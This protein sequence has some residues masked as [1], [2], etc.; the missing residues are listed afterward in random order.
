MQTTVSSR[1]SLHKL[2]ISLR[3]A[4]CA[5]CSTMLISLPSACAADVQ[6]GLVS[7][8][9]LD[10]FQNGVTPD[11]GFTNTMTVQ[12][13]PGLSPGKFGNAFALGGS[14]YATN[15]HSSES[16]PESGL[17][18][19]RANAFTICMWV[20]GPPQTGKYL[21]A[22]G[23]LASN[24][25]LFILQTGQVAANNAKLDVIIRNDA[26][27]TVM[28][29]LVSTTVV[30]DDAWHHVAWVDDNGNARLYVD[31]QL[32]A[33]NFGYT[34]SG[35]FT[36]TST[37]IGTLVR[38]AVSTSAIFNGII[39]DLA[40]WERAL[41]QAEIESVRT[42]SIPTPLTPRPPSLYTQ[43]TDAVKQL[44]DWHRFTALA[45]STR[46]NQAMT[47]QWFR[48]GAPI[49]DATNSFYQT[50][51]LTPAD[52]GTTYSVSVANAIGTTNSSTATLTVLADPPPN[53]QSGL[54]NY[55]PLDTIQQ[56]GGHLT[57]PDLASHTDFVLVN[58]LGTSD[59]VPGYTGNALAFDFV[60]RLAA[61]TNG[62]AI[63]SRTNYTVSMWVQGDFPAQDD[64]RVFS[65][66]SPTN[67]NSLFTLGTDPAGTSASAN[68]FIR[69]DTGA[70]RVASRRST[71]PVFDGIWHHLVWTDAN[72]QGKLYVDGVL[73]E[74]DY[75]YSRGVTTV[76]Q[77]SIGAVLRGVTTGNF[78]F[79]NIDEVAT[80]DRVLTWTEIQ[81]IK[82]QGVPPPAAPIAPSIAGE[83]AD[84]TNNLFVGDTARL[85]VEVNGTFPL[86]FRWAKE[87][88]PI[89]TAANA[90]AGTDTLV[91]SNVQV[92]ASGAYSV[93]ITNIAGAVTSRVAR[94]SV[95]PY[96]PISSGEVLK[97]DFGIAGTG[98]LERG[99]TEFDLGQNGTNFNG[100]GVT[101]GR[102]GGASLAARNRISTPFVTNAPPSLT[103]ARIYNDFIFAGSATEGA[104]M[105]LLIERLAP[106]TPYGLTIWSFDPVSTGNRV[107][108]WTETS[109]GFPVVIASPY[110]F[111]ATNMPAA[112]YQYTFGGLVTSSSSGKLLLEGRRNP[113]S[114]NATG[115]ADIGVFLNAIR[116][117]AHPTGTRI[118]AFYLREGTAHVQVA[119]DYPGQPVQLEES[120]SL[121]PGSWVKSAGATAVATNG[122]AVTFT[123]PFSGNAKFFRASSQKTW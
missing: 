45:Y 32:D 29:H 49:P 6:D 55:W 105:S 58:F 120:A 92:S 34:R 22:E 80:W 107:S 70:A 1:S 87:G 79:G 72:G 111:Q 94:V 15:L 109:S 81:H 16:F 44:G 23:D 35:A 59:L 90:T 118:H 66:G 11:V 31:G 112:D 71:R 40:I 13:T 27:T 56:T 30:F 82:D 19:F 24:S 50:E 93:I 77:T 113:A 10:T 84:I 114:V 64:R 21:F 108:D 110:E 86:S 85:S 116:L 3:F 33:A 38:A 62:T 18:I 76:S 75:S 121:V 119:A 8:W 53:P 46:P 89:P 96:T 42:N 61:R 51:H 83:P 102:I 37:A 47:Y 101:L 60:T 123:V 28:N 36:F 7:Y 68:V 99:F 104:G 20:K 67:N 54:V 43:P 5:A 26:N 73:D 57:S 91:L 88:V 103:Q 122:P 41:S 2:A 98:A 74:T 115:A 48:N 17:P 63:Y 78:F 52:S 69:T 106:N 117:V 100:I 39:D 12:G 14:V 4:V 95:L 9:P 25:P 97:L 65:E